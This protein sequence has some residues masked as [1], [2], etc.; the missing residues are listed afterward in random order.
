M[1]PSSRQPG[2]RRQQAIAHAA[3]VLREGGPDALTSVAVAE[4]MGISQSA[5]YRH[6]RNIDE[7][8]TLASQ[9]IV[10]ELV[11]VLRSKLLSPSIDWRHPGAPKR[12]ARDL[13]DGMIEEA[14]A[15]ET[16]DRWQFADGDL[17]TGIAGVV[18]T[19]QELVSVVLETQFRAEFSYQEPFTQEQLAALDCHAQVILAD[20]FAVARLARADTDRL[21][22]E[23]LA[24]ML[25]YRLVAGW[26]AFLIDMHD[27]IDRPMPPF[28]FRYEPEASTS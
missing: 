27:R 8:T 2:Q 26:V 15:F 3:D 11:A 7:L 1:S 23:T 19:A 24:D 22:S 21:D 14:T 12:I 6:I 20:G 17:G 9:V 16:V 18:R 10:D 25:R 5:V 4:R 13:V 28:K